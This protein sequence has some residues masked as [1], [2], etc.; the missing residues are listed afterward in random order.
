MR[1][2]VKRSDRLTELTKYDQNRKRKEPIFVQGFFWLDC[3]IPGH[4]LWVFKYCYRSPA[5][6]KLT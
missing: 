6:T 4:L 3:R 2:E 1:V 5:V